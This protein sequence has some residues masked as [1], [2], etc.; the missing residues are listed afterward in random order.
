MIDHRLIVPTS[1]F[2][3]DI[4]CRWRCVG[5]DG[6]KV[7]PIVPANSVDRV[8]QAGGG[9][10]IVRGG[11]GGKGGQAIEDRVILLHIRA[12]LVTAIPANGVDF[13]VD[14]HGSQTS[15]CDGH[16]GAGRP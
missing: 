14:H 4:E 3:I 13:V 9:S 1:L 2:H 7:V 12:V 15:A 5:L 6:G 10:S 8:V 11:Y 16:S